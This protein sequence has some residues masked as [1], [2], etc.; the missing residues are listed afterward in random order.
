MTWTHDD[1]Q[2]DLAASRIGNGEIV[3]Q[4][5][6]LG[7]W[8][9]GGEMDVFSMKL[10]RTQ[11]RP[12][13]YEIKISRADFM[14]DIRSEKYKQYEQWCERGYFAVPRGLVAKEEV[15]TGWGLMLR[16]DKG[17]YSVKQSRMGPVQIDAWR[18]LFLAVILKMFPGPWSQ[19][20]R[21]MKRDAYLKRGLN[22]IWGRELGQEVNQIIQRN[23]E[24]EGSQL[25]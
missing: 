6:S 5:L 23:R 13:C 25:H 9:G 22:Q 14:S 19:P 12:T 15:P 11:P 10:S 4:K 17:W 20:T 3:L 21:E 7:Y 1:L 18:P 16:G 8:G 24:L 2:A